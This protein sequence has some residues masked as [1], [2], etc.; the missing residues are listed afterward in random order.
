MLVR[1]LAAVAISAFLGVQVQA[2]TTDPSV[3]TE[4]G[5][6]SHPTVAV[7]RDAKAEGR[8][9]DFVSAVAGGVLRASKQRPQERL[10]AMASLVEHSVDWGFVMRSSV[11]PAAMAVLSD[12]ERGELARSML[13][14]SASE[15]ATLFNGYHGEQVDVTAVT[16]I[17]PGLAR[18]DT[19]L[20]DPR[21]ADGASV[22]WIVAG[23]DSGRPSFRD[24]VIDGTS[25]LAN[26]QQVLQAMWNEVDQNKARFLALVANP[27]S[28]EAQE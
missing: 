25:M 15:F 28:Y 8:A 5:A 7:A 10:T 18:V 20:R 13:A 22:V 4:Q 1:V 9:V 3:D 26:Q 16:M 6:T 12:A 24:L 17:G 14:V 23:L 19:R 21:V 27:F 11:P 2:Y